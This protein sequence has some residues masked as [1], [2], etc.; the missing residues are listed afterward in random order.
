MFGFMPTTGRTMPIISQTLQKLNSND[1][2]EILNA[3]NNLMS[4]LS[5]ATDSFAENPSIRELIISLCG[6]LDRFPALPDISVV[7]LQCLN[8]IVDINPALSG[9]IVKCG[10]TKQ[11]C[12]KLSNVD[13]FEALEDSIKLLEKMSNENIVSLLEAKVFIYI[14][15]LIDF[16]D[17]NL[18]KNVLKCC[19]NITKGIISYEEIEKYIQ[20]G[21]PFLIT[22]MRL[23]GSAEIEKTIC[24]LAIQNLFNILNCAKK[25]TTA[26]ENKIKDLCL[27]LTE[28]GVIENLF[29]LFI[30][31][32]NSKNN[33]KGIIDPSKS[34]VGE[35]TVNNILKVFESLCEIDENIV[36]N[37]LDKGMLDYIYQVLYNELGMT[38]DNNEEINHSSIED[39]EMTERNDEQNLKVSSNLQSIYQGIFGLLISFFP[40]V[41]QEREL[42]GNERSEFNLLD[43]ETKEEKKDYKSMKILNPKNSKYFNFFSEKILFLLIKNI[44]NIPSTYTT[45]MVIRLITMYILVNEQQNID[46]YID[47]NNLSNS[48]SKMLDSRDT[49]YIIEV[50]ILV[51]LIMTQT[52]K[53]FIIP[54]I[55]EGIVENIK[56]ANR[57][58]PNNFYIAKETDLS[59][60]KILFGNKIKNAPSAKK[61][62]ME[63]KESMDSLTLGHY[64]SFSSSSS[65][66][67]T[68]TNTITDFIKARSNDL[69]EIYFNDAEIKNLIQMITKEKGG[70]GIIDPISIMNQLEEGKEK[71]K[72]GE[73]KTE[74]LFNILNLIL[75]QKVTFF[76]L[77]KSEII[78]YLAKHFD[79]NFL[80][81]YNNSVDSDKKTEVVLCG[82]YNKNIIQKLN[83]FLSLFK[84]EDNINNISLER[85]IQVLQLGI[86]SMNCFKLYLYESETNNKTRLNLFESAFREGGSLIGPKRITLTFTFQDENQIL[87]SLEKDFPRVFKSLKSY[88][89]NQKYRIAIEGDESFKNVKRIVLRVALDDKND[90]LTDRD[91]EFSEI[92]KLMIMQKERRNRKN[93]QSQG[94]NSNDAIPESDIFETEIL[95]RLMERRRER[96]KERQKRNSGEDP[97]KKESSEINNE[98]VNEDNSDNQRENDEKEIKRFLDSFDVEFWIGTTKENKMIIQDDDNINETIRDA[99]KNFNSN[100]FYSFIS[101]FGISFSIKLKDSSKKENISEKMIQKGIETYYQRKNEKFTKNETEEFLFLNFYFSHIINSQSVYIIKRA[102]PFFYLISTIHLI[103]KHFSHLFNLQNKG[104]KKKN[105][106]NLKMTSLLL[107]QVKDPFAVSYQSIPKWCRELS[108]NYQYFMSFPARFLLFK[109]TSFDNRRNLGNLF[110]FLKNYMGENISGNSINPSSGVKR[111]KFKISRE[112]ILEDALTVIKK[113]QNFSGYLEFDYLN[114]IGTGLGP[115]LE[116]YSLISQKIADKK[117]LWYNTSDLTLFPIPIQKDTKNVEEIKNIFLILGYFTARAL[118]DDR[119]INIPLNQIFWDLVLNRPISFHSIKKIDPNL[120]SFIYSPK[121]DTLIKD[122]EA[123][124]LNMTLPWNQSVELI[125]GGLNQTVTID[126][127]ETY[128][129]LVFNKLLIEGQR[130]I[131][132]SFTEGFNKVFPIEKIKVFSSVE[133]E[134]IICSNKSYDDETWSY[135]NL[136]QNIIP[137]H[138]FTKESLMY[139]GLIEILIGFNQEQRKKFLKF[140]TGCDRLPIGGFKNLN[141]KLTVVMFKSEILKG[142][143]IFASDDHLPSVMTCQNYLK[144]PNYSSVDILRVKLECAISEGGSAF[145]LT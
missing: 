47:E 90:Y 115:T 2:I 16:F 82:N 30:N 17:L 62:P 76:E 83:E 79:E 52:P 126:N 124:D 71:L 78:L 119:L 135:E 137:S 145:L 87:P 8:Y 63:N 134:E 59:R 114:E 64:M 86:S 15:Q 42:K 34:I 27:T 98:E 110:S 131:I 40:L 1:E 97:S 127:L 125:K 104:I 33:S 75:N 129:S 54:F 130:E 81:N 141:P 4:E 14:L 68:N 35:D 24:D 29:E 140:V 102:S 108:S 65:I 38:K 60:S 28:A 37:L 93:Q 107:K 106:E 20:D 56:K 133:L 122:L 89:E 139:N 46:K 99:K 44:L 69:L 116:F 66:S 73:A 123:A 32:Y 92:F 118:F 36:N 120:Y 23:D 18:R 43:A 111:I 85:F 138:G 11:I 57:M 41:E 95:H 13:N 113:F 25:F 112:K 91:D 101:E 96:Q 55:R 136:T 144:I 109:T 50:F 58:D 77:E 94:E 84:S 5:I 6:L 3:L 143:E 67:N 61:I 12:N 142:G 22:L 53:K 132:N 121:E 7:S 49:S 72:N 100:D 39:E 103:Q 26:Y 9:I 45:L 105:F 48:L 117:Y 128:K 70:K 10:G 51:D 88:I 31:F 74:D 19:L 80:I 21:I